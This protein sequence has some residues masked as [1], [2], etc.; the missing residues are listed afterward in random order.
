MSRPHAEVRPRRGDPSIPRLPAS[1][2]HAASRTPRARRRSHVHGAPGDLQQT[3]R[4]RHE[5][6]PLL[7]VSR[8]RLFV[9]PKQLGAIDVEIWTWA[10]GP[11]TEE[12][13]ETETQHVDVPESRLEDGGWR[14]SELPLPGAS[15]VHPTS[16]PSSPVR[17]LRAAVLA[18]AAIG[19]APWAR[20]P[21]PAP[22]TLP[23]TTRY[24]LWLA[25]KAMVLRDVIV[26][27]D[28]IRG[29]PVDPLGGQS[30]AW[31]A[32]ARAEVD[33]F[34]IRPPDPG[35]LLGAGVGAGLLAGIAL[36]IGVFRGAAGY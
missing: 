25:G 23:P 17:H 9:K 24:Q 36:T 21:A 15:I 8:P 18:L 10:P 31:V 14:C 16:R 19:C 34:R 13:E 1:T 29:H 4:E 5:V 20:I 26:E 6:D 33:S 11:E 2:C 35:N 30:Q 7:Q 32:V 3:I 12:Y 27:D 22:A 28:S